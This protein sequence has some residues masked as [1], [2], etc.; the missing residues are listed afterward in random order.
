VYIAD[1]RTLSDPRLVR[2]LLE[3]GEKMPS[4][5]KF[6]NRAAAAQMLAPFIWRKPVSPRFQFPCLGDMR[7]RLPDW[8]AWMIGKIHWRSCIRHC[9]I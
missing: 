3:T 2:Y 1:A 9:V 6:A 5:F 7:I 4:P 8:L